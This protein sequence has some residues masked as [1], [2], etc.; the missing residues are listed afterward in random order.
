MSGMIRFD[1][2]Y[3]HYRDRAV[4]NGLSLELSERRIGIVGSNGSGK[5]TLSRL[6]NGLLAPS[7]GHI[8]VNGLDTR[9]QA[10]K[11]RQQVGLV[12]QNPD[13]QIVLPTVAEDLAFGLRHQKV[14]KPRIDELIDEVLSRHDLQDYRDT[15]IHHLSG[16]QKQLV[17]LSGVLVMSPQWLVLDEPTT[18]LDLRNRRRITRVIEQLEQRAIVISHDLELMQHMERIIVLD[19]G[20]V[21]LDASPDIALPFYTEHMA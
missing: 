2:V 9:T 11:V 3:Y 7:E 1:N 16:G 5:S 20:K 6:L 4:I 13:S 18:L 21:A 8:T 10:R 19:K 15:P 14:P 17:A 12:F